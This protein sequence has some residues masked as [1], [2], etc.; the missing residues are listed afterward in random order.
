MDSADSLARGLAGTRPKPESAPVRVELNGHAPAAAIGFWTIADLV[1]RR[2]H[3]LVIGGILGFAGIFELTWL[4][5]PPKFTALT[6]LLRYETPAQ[7]D[8]LKTTPLSSETF[9]GLIA[10]PDVL[11]RVA[12]RM[13]RP[14]PPEVLV[15]SLKVDADDD[16]DIVKVYWSARD[17]RDA[18]E[19]ANLYSGEVVSF[20][21]ELQSRQAGEVADDYLKK[22]VAAMDQDILALHDQFRGLPV[23]DPLTNKLA[24]VGNDLNALGQHLSEAPRVSM[25]TVKLTEKLQTSLAELSDLTLRY[26]DAHPLVEQKRAQIAALKEQISQAST[27]AGVGSGLP[28]NGLGRAYFLGPDGK[29]MLDPDYEVILAKL[30]AL[31]DARVRIADRQREAE[32]YANDPPGAVRVVAPAN[33]KTIRSNHRRIKIGLASMFGGCLGVGCS[34]GLMLLVEVF[35]RRLKTVDDVQRVTRLP[36]LT[37]LGDLNRMPGGSRAQWAFRTW[38]LLQGQLSKSANHGLVCGITSSSAG[39]GR[40]TWIHLLAEA[41]SLTGF[42]VL[43]IATRP[44]SSAAAGSGEITNGS[45]EPSASNGS[46]MAPGDC[47]AALTPNVLASP[48]QVTEQLTNPNSAPVVHIPLPGWVWNLERRRQWREALNQWRKIDNLVIFV[49][50]PPASVPEAVLLG[51]NLPNLVWLAESGAADAAATRSQ[52]E[53]LRHARCHLVGAV[54]NR[55]ISK[56]IKRLFPRWIGGV[57]LLALFPALLT[58][59]QETNAP[60][61]EEPP[62]APMPAENEVQPDTNLSFSVVNPAVRAPW[63]Q[64]LTLGPGDVLTFELYGQPNLTRAEVAIPPDGRVSYLEAQ[65]VMAEGLTV[66]GLRARLDEE[67]SKYR[68]A[69]HT[70][71]IPIA[72]RSKK[73]FVLGEVVQRGVYILDRP[74]TVIEALARARGLLNGQ[75]DQ[76]TLDLADLQRTFLMRHGKRMPLDFERLFRGGDLSQNIPIEPGDYLYFPSASLQQVYVLGEVALPGPVTYRPDLT[77]AEAI[78]ARGGFTEKAFKS[79]VL[80]V[81]GSLSH[82]QATIVNVMAA[83]QGRGLDFKLQPKDI[84]YVNW[85]PLSYGEDLADLA[86]TAFVQSIVTSWVGADVVT[87]TR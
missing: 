20:T 38:T 47:P 63:Q 37:T 50:L 40:S 3:W 25:L 11:R 1:A 62:A 73:Y 46:G 84:I 48:A 29:P 65:D 12:A 51:A 76:D 23:S 75:V 18:V 42:R 44:S 10:S 52:L 78:A 86:T 28:V 6:Q 83:V 64:H 33:L 87:P 68:R 79:R 34:L 8:F 53:T 26:T 49:E 27:N 80:V 21:K 70:M 9:A 85:R 35:E 69:P 77:A 61:V 39:E 41:A 55:E 14:L 60:A 31:E 58:A 5:L 66:D 59:A 82:P 81:R 30:H 24:Q 19:L 57:T 36:V 71:L 2:W 67:L 7:S 4:Y 56:P 16:S 72:Y 32:L 22:Q 13:A 45:P 74:I 15:K 17:P 54:L 43:T